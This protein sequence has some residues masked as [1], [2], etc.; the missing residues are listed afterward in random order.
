MKFHEGPNKGQIFRKA[1]EP[2][3]LALRAYVG[4]K[5]ILFT[6]WVTLDPRK[7]DFWPVG[8]SLGNPSLSYLQNTYVRIY[9]VI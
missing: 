7:P 5:K 2:A 3:P 1:T 6:K 4:K 8:R 9:D